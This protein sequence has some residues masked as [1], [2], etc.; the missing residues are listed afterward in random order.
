MNHQRRSLEELVR[1]FAAPDADPVSSLVE[2]IAGIRPVNPHDVESA[3]RSLQALSHLLEH[4]PDLRLDF[5]NALLDFLTNRRAVSFYVDSGVFQNRGFFSESLRRISCTILP[6]EPNACYLKDVVGIIFNRSSDAHWVSA[7]P[8]P[9]WR[10]FLSALHLEDVD[11]GKCASNLFEDILEA[12]RVISYRI[13]AIGLEPELIRVEPALEN[14]ESPFLAQNPE[15]LRYLTEYRDWWH[16]QESSTP[17][18]RHLHVLFDQSRTVVERVRTRASREG[19]SLSLTLLLRR[20]SQHLNR[21]DSLIDVLDAYAQRRSINDVIPSLV[22]II[23]RLIA[24]EARKNNLR[25]FWRANIDLLARRV[26]DNAGRTGEHYITSERGEYFTMFRS[27]ALGGF[28]IAIMALGKLFITGAHLPPLTEALAVCLNYGLGFVLIHIL[29]GTV[30]TK[31]PA[32]TAATIAAGIGQNNTGQRHL[33]QIALLVARTT[34]SQLVAILGNVTV[35]VPTA[36][37]LGAALTM[38]QGH[39]YPESAKAHLLLDAVHPWLSGSLLFAAIA[40]VCLFITGLISGYY[41]NLAAYNRI[42]QRLN[43]LRV[44]RWLLGEARWTRVCRYIENNL[45]AL[46]GN[47]FFGFLLGG[48]TAFGVLFG[49]PVDIRHIAF[50]SAYLGFSLNALEYALPWHEIV[51]AVI[52]VSLI[53]LVNLIVSFSLSLR[54][55]CRARQI[56]IPRGALLLR[57]FKLFLRQ[58]REFF[59]PPRA[60]SSKSASLEAG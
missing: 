22:V 21:C 45:G 9:I 46:A 25:E 55:A 6:D 19:T 15:M 30:A 29:H 41:D 53:G 11:T 48:V 59:L 20:I 57:I 56:T 43:S 12:L 24:K 28:V 13:A 10:D 60:E 5:R 14:F 7:V 2:L 54:V 40:G 26:T 51:I 16:R 32:M 27:A 50:S 58:P 1:S 33:D 42:P 17:D 31:Q 3:S 52:G 23:K 18:A 34:R 36:I 38:Y 39:P 44:P 4:N 37:L 49:L 8:D 35:A 47:F